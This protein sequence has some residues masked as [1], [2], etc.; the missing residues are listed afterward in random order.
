MVIKLLSINFYPYLKKTPA[1]KNIV[2][3]KYFVLIGQ[4]WSNNA[5]LF[6]T[7]LCSYYLLN[8]YLAYLRIVFFFI[9]IE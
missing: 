6:S 2:S 7:V 8:S 9:R 1:N 3:N 5:K 4:F